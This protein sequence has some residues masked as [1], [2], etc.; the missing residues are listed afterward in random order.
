MARGGERA[1]TELHVVRII[2]QAGG[3]GLAAWRSLQG[4]AP[5]G[6]PSLKV[7]TPDLMVKA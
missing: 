1:T 5:V 6:R 2:T 7:M 4:C 3:S